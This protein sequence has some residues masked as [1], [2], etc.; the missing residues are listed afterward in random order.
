MSGM[1]APELAAGRHFDLLQE[2]WAELSHV[3]HHGSTA[4]ICVLTAA[5]ERLL[6]VDVDKAH[7]V[8]ETEMRT[9]LGFWQAL[10]HLMCGLAHDAEHVA[11]Q[12]A[13]RVMELFEEDPRAVAHN[14]KTFELLQPEAAFRHGATA[15]H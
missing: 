4:E 8:L 10:P 9:K 7:A 12:V 14:R 15:L 11:R 13:V 6:Q 3:V 1:R 2:C 5:E